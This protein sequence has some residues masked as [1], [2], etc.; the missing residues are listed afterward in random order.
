MIYQRSSCNGLLHIDLLAKDESH[1]KLVSK[2]LLLFEKTNPSPGS[3]HICVEF[4]AGTPAP[5]EMKGGQLLVNN[6]IIDI[7]QKKIESWIPEKNQKF[8]ELNHMLIQPLGALLQ[9][10]EFHTLHGALVSSDTHVIA[11]LGTGGSGK[12]T[13]SSVLSLG[14]H[15]LLCDDMFFLAHKNNQYQFAPLRTHV[16]ISNKDKKKCFSDKELETT[17]IS[18]VSSGKKIV[19]IFPCYRDL[20]ISPELKP[21]SHRVAFKNLITDNLMM[22]TGQSDCKKGRMEIFDFL[23]Q[24]VKDFDFFE[25]V[26]NDQNLMHIEAEIYRALYSC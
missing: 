13:S 24:L 3:I 25:L 21:I 10:L 16:K 1:L 20:Q 15:A 14:R 17:A 11:F 12:S 9:A 26:Y 5:Q 19:F 4:H 18:D 22:A 2:K 7:Q 8:F 6:S 23:H